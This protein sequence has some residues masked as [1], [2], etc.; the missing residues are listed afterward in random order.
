MAHAELPARQRTLADYLAILRRRKWI[1]LVPILLVPIAAYLYSAQQ[2]KVYGA[3]AEVLLSRQDLG[4]ALTGADN[5]AIFG[6][7]DRFAE[8][9]SV[10]ARVPEVA[11]R[12]LA[13]ARV[14]G[15]SPD[16]LLA[17]STVSVQGNADLLSFTVDDPDPQRAARLAAAY[18]RAFSRFRRELD[19][20]NLASARED[21]QR[22]IVQLRREGL[23]DTALYRDLTSKAQ[24]L[25]TLELLQTEQKVVSAP[26]DA[27]LV[28]PAPMRTAMLGVFL[29]LALGI[30]A[31]LLWE[32]LD[33]RLRDEGEIERTLG[34]P[35]L[36]RLPA[37]RQHKGREQLAMMENASDAEAEAVRRFR[38]NVE[39]ANL[40]HDANMIMVTSS[41]SGEGKSVTISNLALALA[42]A[43]RRVVLVDLDLRKPGVAKLFG[44][45][46]RPGLTDVAIERVGLDEALV[47]VSLTTS[48]PAQ[49]AS[50]RGGRARAL[51]EGSEAPAAEGQGSLWL[52]PAGF[53]P[54]NPGELVGT[55]AVASIL[56]SLRERA[57]FVLV[58]APPLLAVS[59]GVTLSRRVDALLVVVR[60]GMVDRPLLRELGKQ[61]EANPARKLG[62]VLAG[63]DPAEL[64]GLGAYGYG[65]GQVES[66]AGE[67]RRSAQPAP[68]EPV[69]RAPV[70]E[71]SSR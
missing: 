30:G 5:P 16:D 69:L 61:L 33:K 71:S 23:T 10:L 58:D 9:Q 22:S 17:A 29:G 49:F 54:A 67:E 57:D 26:Q 8:T 62:F 53:L 21:L 34:L 28:A 2:P 7:E 12:A 24:E 37:P 20:E 46:F 60:L 35:L 48:A 52:L 70:S 45:E 38:A 31:A 19:T 3:S 11:R 66:E 39:F 47:S 15:L 44:L 65:Y 42:R 41:V 6:D 55:Q 50:R 64:Y 51:D 36:A 4:A 32:T 1:A 18:A 25:R 13:I 68:V 43:G 63:V 14:T 59:D 27:E 40:D 56:D